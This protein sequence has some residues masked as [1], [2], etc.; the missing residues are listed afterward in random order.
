MA[1]SMGSFSLV[2]KVPVRARSWEEPLGSPVGFF[3]P[4]RPFRLVDLYV[5]NISKAFDTMKKAVERD[6]RQKFGDRLDKIGSTP[7]ATT[8]CSPTVNWFWRGY[9]SRFLWY[10]KK[11][12]WSSLILVPSLSMGD[13]TTS[14]STPSLEAEEDKEIL[15]QD[16]DVGISNPG[17]SGISHHVLAPSDNATPVRL[18]AKLMPRLKSS[19]PTHVGLGTDLGNGI[20]P[21]H[22]TGPKTL[23]ILE[24]T[25]AM[26]ISVGEDIPLKQ[27]DGLKRQRLE[28][29]YDLP[30]SDAILDE[31]LGVKA[32]LNVEV[33]KDEVFWEQRARVNWLRNGD[34]NTQFFHSFASHRRKIN[35]IDSLLADDGSTITESDALFTMATDYFASLFTTQGSFPD[36]EIMN[37]IP[38]FAESIAHSV[39]DCLYS[40]EHH[41][42]KKCKEFII[43]IWGIWHARNKLLHEGFSQRAHKVV[44][45]CKSY[46]REIEDVSASLDSGQQVRVV[47][48]SPPIS[49]MVKINVDAAFDTVVHSSISGV[50]V[51][52]S[53]GHLL[54]SC[55]Q[56]NFAI[57][58]CF[59]AEAQA[60]IKGLNFARDLGCLHV[61]LE[62]DSLTMISKLRSAKDDISVLRP[63][64]SEAKGISRSFA[65]CQFVFIPR[66]GN[67]V[68]HRLAQFGKSRNADFFW[69][70]EIP[71]PLI[72]LVE[73]DRRSLDPS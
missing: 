5:E 66:G 35:R 72:V 16:E 42:M 50:V 27:T 7:G 12:A 26:D 14:S 68:A 23:Q 70:E 52:D 40:R 19:D 62:S 20:G 41:S 4:P 63:Y 36:A 46:V 58:S 44:S 53:E 38:R 1:C 32:G 24:P 69:V 22:T 73:V 59:A 56:L 31:I 51:Q 71:S 13:T 17:F 8:L 6:E 11:S 25:D 18:E 47:S 48:W 3:R 65:S 61:T 55:V 34:R 33:D 10:Y 60:V 64:I 54:G 43:L 67:V 45:F 37:Q 2:I 39:R 9:M 30:V 29:L 28:H 21:S 15:L 57:A 49:P